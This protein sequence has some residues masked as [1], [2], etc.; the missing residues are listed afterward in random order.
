MG[1]VT[2]KSDAR[3]A[4]DQAR[5]EVHLRDGQVHTREF[6]AVAGSP[7]KPMSRKSLDMK[8]LQLAAR[9]VG[10]VK[11]LRPLDLRAA[12]QKWTCERFSRPPEPGSVTADAA[13]PA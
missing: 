10:D 4:L 13:L 3:Y 9:W 2:L 6:L 11:A 7:D 5:V 8:F 1:R 12:G